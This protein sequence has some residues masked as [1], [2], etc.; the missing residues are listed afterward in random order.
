MRCALG[1][2]ARIGGVKPE[3]LWAMER[4]KEVMWGHGH[5]CIFTSIMDRQHQK[6]S[7]HYVGY[8]FD[9]SVSAVN[10]VDLHDIEDEIEDAIG[11]DYDI[12]M[13]LVQQIIH[14]EYQPEG[15]LNL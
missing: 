2:N 13:N 1:P 11:R 4:V 7:L 5:D 9:F 14:V 6:N 10:D 15:G 12:V 8:A 3:T